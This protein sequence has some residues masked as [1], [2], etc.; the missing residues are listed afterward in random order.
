MVKDAEKNAEADRKRREQIDTKN[1]A[2]SLV[3]QAQKQLKDLG[4]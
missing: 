3:Y 4:D 2:D 1:Q